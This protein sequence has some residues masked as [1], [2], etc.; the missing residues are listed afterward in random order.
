MLTGA[1]RSPWQSDFKF[2]SPLSFSCLRGDRESQCTCS[3]LWDHPSVHDTQQGQMEPKTETPTKWIIPKWLGCAPNCRFLARDSQKALSLWCRLVYVM[4][5]HCFC[6]AWG[7]HGHGQHVFI[8]CVYK[9]NRSSEWSKRQM[10]LNNVDFS[11]M[12]NFTSQILHLKFNLNWQ[13][14]LFFFHNRINFPQM[15]TNWTW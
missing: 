9:S 7:H 6:V 11:P 10:V 13:K 8:T 12:P 3:F 4:K 1:A 15:E 2:P 14:V 5:M